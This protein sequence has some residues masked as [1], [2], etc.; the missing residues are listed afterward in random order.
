MFN[1][2]RCIEG[3]L[4]GRVGHQ[5]DAGYRNNLSDLDTYQIL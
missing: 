3:R 4:S 1:L 5:F 2:G